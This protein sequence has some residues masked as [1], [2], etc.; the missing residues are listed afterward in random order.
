MRTRIRYLVAYDI[1]NPRRLGKVF[2]YLRKVGFH[3][4]YSVFLANLTPA[5]LKLLLT[6]L[7][8]MIDPHE[9]DLRI[10]PLPRDPDWYW[11]GT[12]PLPEAMLYMDDGAPL[13]PEENPSRLNMVLEEK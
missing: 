9:D 12:P 8:A 4:Q 13:L 3:L 2:R 1:A 10:Y 11:L 7:E 5:E 6:D